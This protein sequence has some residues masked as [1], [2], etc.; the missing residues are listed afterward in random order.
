MAFLSVAELYRGDALT[1]SATF[2]EVVNAITDL[3]MVG[4]ASVIEAADAFR[5]SIVRV[6]ADKSNEALEGEWIVARDAFVKA[7]QV[8]VG[9]KV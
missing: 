6:R 5:E 3:H 8:A 7:A 2:S 1:E 4:P 9:I